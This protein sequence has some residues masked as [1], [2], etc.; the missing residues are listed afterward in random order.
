M[1]LSR[2]AAKT[3]GTIASP[4]ATGTAIKTQLFLTAPSDQAGEVGRL[5]ISFGQTDSTQPRVLVEVYWTDDTI[6]GGTPVTPTKVNAI[7]PATSRFTAGMAPNEPPNK[8][9]IYSE[10]VPP[11]IPWVME[12]FGELKTGRTIAIQTSVGT[13]VPSFKARIPF[14]E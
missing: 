3:N 7:G 4:V 9:I 5:S 11:N 13:T 2:W 12:Y 10:L 1:S 14:T 6:S 8:S